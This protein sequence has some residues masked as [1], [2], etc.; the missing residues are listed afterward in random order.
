MKTLNGKIALITG[1][2]SGIGRL[3]AL[4][5]AERGARVMVWDLNAQAIAEL[6]T[7]ARTRRLYISGM[8]CDVSD[9]KAVY[10]C[11]KKTA[12]TIGPVDILVNNAGIVSGTTFLDTPDEKMIKTMEINAM[13]NFW[14]VKA[15]LPGMLERNSGHLVTISSA[16]GIVGVTG[17]ADYSASKFAAFG[18]HEAIRT[19]IRRLGKKVHTTVVCPFFINTGMFDGVS[20]RFPLILPILKSE[21]AARRIVQA[22]MKKKKR[23]MMPRFVYSVYLL[24]LLPVALMDALADFFGVN[25]AMD[26]F[27]GRK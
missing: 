11:A 12:E 2:A 8:R 19:E 24:R 3:V 6:E 17:L 22:V 14:T 26:N 27:R 7:E 16:A 23:L 10:E 4:A 21:Y 15:F 18:F 5:F 9:R 1:G 25:R 13:A 20:T